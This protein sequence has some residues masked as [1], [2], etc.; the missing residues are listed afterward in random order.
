MF[1]GF[2]FFGAFCSRVFLDF[3]IFGFRFYFGFRV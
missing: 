2:V 3:G 1:G